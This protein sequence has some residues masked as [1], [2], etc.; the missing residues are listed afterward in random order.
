MGDPVIIMRQSFQIRGDGFCMIFTDPNTFPQ[1]IHRS[2]R[3]KA[4]PLRTRILVDI[5]LYSWCSLAFS[6]SGQRNGYEF[7]NH[8][9]T[10]PMLLGCGRIIKLR[11]HLGPNINFSVDR[12]VSAFY[13]QQS[14]ARTKAHGALDRSSGKAGGH[15][16]FRIRNSFPGSAST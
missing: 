2:V 10:R 9:R 11:D 13:V 14:H 16:F 5:V 12:K 7:R 15:R 1:S 3:M 6:A 4:L 8:L